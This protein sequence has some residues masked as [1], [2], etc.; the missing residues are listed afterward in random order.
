ML[1]TLQSV[2]GEKAG[3]VAVEQ[4]WGDY[5]AAR[6]TDAD[7]ATLSRASWAADAGYLGDPIEVP[8]GPVGAVMK[9]EGSAEP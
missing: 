5:Q 1:L 8:T 9:A 4:A 3:K 7:C 6:W 2:I